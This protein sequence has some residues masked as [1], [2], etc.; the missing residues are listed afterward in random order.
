MRFVV[1]KEEVQQVS[2]RAFQVFPDKYHS[3]IASYSSSRA[4]AIGSSKAVVPLTLSYIIPIIII[5][6]I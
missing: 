5:N 1:G 2:F 6:V 3:N 4:V